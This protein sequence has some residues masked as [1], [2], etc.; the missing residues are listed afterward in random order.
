M[1]Q[2]YSLHSMMLSFQWRWRLRKIKKM[3]MRQGNHLLI[4]SR[5]IEEIRKR[6]RKLDEVDAI[7]THLFLSFDAPL[8]AKNDAEKTNGAGKRRKVGRER[9]PWLGSGA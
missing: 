6:I 4:L 5:S 1:K 3:T 7:R 2:G 8:S 9:F